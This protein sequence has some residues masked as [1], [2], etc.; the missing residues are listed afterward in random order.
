MDSK[1]KLKSLTLI[2]LILQLATSYGQGLS[3]KNCE[4]PQCK[5]YLN[6]AED[7]FYIFSSLVGDEYQVSNNAQANWNFSLSS[8]LASIKRS[9]IHF[10]ARISNDENNSAYMSFYNA[11]DSS[12]S[13]KAI[14]YTQQLSQVTVKVYRRINSFQSYKK[15]NFGSDIDNLIHEQTI[16]IDDTSTFPEFSKGHFLITFSSTEDVVAKLGI[17][18]NGLS[19]L[20]HIT[21]GGL[22]GVQ[23]ND[24]IVGKYESF[25]AMEL[26]AGLYTLNTTAQNGQPQLSVKRTQSGG[27]RE[28]IYN[29]IEVSNIYSND[30][31]NF[32]LT[33]VAYSDDATI[34]SYAYRNLENGYSFIEHF[35][36]QTGH[37]RV[38]NNYEDLVVED[39][40]FYHQSYGDV[41]MNSDGSKVA[42]NHRQSSGTIG[43][44]YSI[45]TAT[46]YL[47]DLQTLNLDAVRITNLCE[48]ASCSFTRGINNLGLDDSGSYM[49]Y[50]QSFPDELTVFDVQGVE[51]DISFTG[52]QFYAI[53]SSGNNLL[54]NSNHNDLV[55]NDQ[56][57]GADVFSYEINSS[58]F[59]L[60]SVLNGNQPIEGTNFKPKYGINENHVLF[61]SNTGPQL[62]L[63]LY[64]SQL[65]YAR[66]ITEVGEG[67]EFA[68]DESGSQIVFTSKLDFNHPRPDN[69]VRLW[70]YDITQNKLTLKA[71]SRQNLKWPHIST[72]GN[73]IVV[74]AERDETL[75]LA[76]KIFV[77]KN[78]R[79]LSLIDL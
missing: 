70:L 71:T 43:L 58:S 54:L 53:N 52:H 46:T 44:P 30:T 36:T 32:I 28:L 69:N 20:S 64:D 48:T 12:F 51:D 4:Q 42:Y 38:L 56:N 61:L 22:V 63:Y 57:E 13:I 17:T 49:A 75:Q 73:T 14:D 15:I 40:E 5:Q 25:S 67:S 31:I 19:A 2:L 27:L 7:G 35:D 1:F 11:E 21:F 9:P 41:I 78:Q 10:G 55:A 72:D 79:N 29:N 37:Q 47:Y 16:S 50:T 74:V 39:G 33:D 62:S 6:I 76:D 34:F 24:G 8:D 77:I 23:E 66:H 3:D 26:Q 59:K 68:I 60:L 18:I 65:G 45:S